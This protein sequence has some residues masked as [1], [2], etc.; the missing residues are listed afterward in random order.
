MKI[1]LVYPNLYGM[2][3]LPPAIGLFTAILKRE[4]HEVKLFDTTVY[5]D[6]TEFNSDKAKSENL[7]ARPYDDSLLK[8]AAKNTDAFL[9]FKTLVDEY[10]PEL[11]AVSV[12]ED[13]YPIAISLLKTSGA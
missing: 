6:L 1:L 2:N 4:G 8:N 13:M 10:A 3:M 7:N 9:D 11:I 5:E 12:T